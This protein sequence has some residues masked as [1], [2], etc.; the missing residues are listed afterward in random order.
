MLTLYTV[1]LT[2][3]LVYWAILQSLLVFPWDRVHP[4]SW[5]ITEKKIYL[6][7]I[8]QFASSKSIVPGS[9]FHQEVVCFQTK[10]I[11]LS[12]L[13]Y[14]H[15]TKNVS[16]KD[17]EYKQVR[18]HYVWGHIVICNF[19]ELNWQVTLNLKRNRVWIWYFNWNFTVCWS[20]HSRLV[21]NAE[22]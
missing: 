13:V 22:V 19:Q 18:P 8:K 14:H 17:S 5:S 3:K 1:T 16:Q 6:K 15:T 11:W 21:E 7:S 4:L 10:K 2:V 12:H 20:V 9:L